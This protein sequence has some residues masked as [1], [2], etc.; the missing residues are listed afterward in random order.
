MLDELA[1]LRRQEKIWE[2]LKHAVS[3][4]SRPLFPSDDQLDYITENVQGRPI[5]SEATLR[6]F[7]R[8]TVDI[9]VKKIFKALQGDGSLSQEFDIKGQVTFYDHMDSQPTSTDH[10]RGEQVGQ[11]QGARSRR[12]LNRRTDQFCVRIVAGER[13]T[14]VYAVEF[15]APHKLILA[16]LVFHAICLVAAVYTQIF[17]YMQD[18]G[19]Q[20]GYIR[21]GEAFVFLHIPTDPTILQYS[22]Y[23]PNQD[24]LTGDKSRFHQTAVDWYNTANKKLTEWEVK[25]LDVLRDIPEIIRKEPPPSNYRPSHWKRE[26]KTHYTRSR[27]RCDPDVSTPKGSPSEGSNSDEDRSMRPYCTMACIRGIVHR[28]PLNKN[29]PNLQQHSSPRHPMGPREFTYKLHCQL[30]QNRDQGFEILHICGRTGYTIVIKATTEE[31]PYSFHAKVNN[32]H[33]LQSLQGYQIPVCLGHFKPNSG[34]RLQKVISNENS[35]FFHKERDK[36]L[37]VLW[38]HG[39]VHKDKKWRNMLWDELTGRLVVIDLEDIEWIKQPRPLQPTSAN[40]SGRHIAGVQQRKEGHR[41]S[42]PAACIS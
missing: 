2:Q 41:S 35:D 8:D 27:A 36:C 20:Y 34:I 16:E 13:R 23:V 10:G 29:C 22:L 42:L 25:Y 9:F 5:Y 14:L 39:V 38:S 4:T 33:R 19:I 40:S 6:N 37:A 26:P 1:E 18:L 7:E 31:K 24:V 30:V 11:S 21:T 12:R 3:F 28:G 15:K 17:S 32:Y